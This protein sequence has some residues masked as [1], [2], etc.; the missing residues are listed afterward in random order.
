[1]S[2]PTPT[3]GFS[4]FLHKFLCLRSAPRELWII[5]IAYVLENIAYKLSSG[6][7]LPLWLAHELGMSDTT[8]GLTIG[9]WS[10]LLT[11]FTVLVGS[12]TDAVGIRRTFLLGFAICA[13]A[14]IAMLFSSPQIIPLGL[15]LLPLA[16]G[17]ALMTPV[18]T[19]AMKRYS[20]AAQRSVAFSLYY[21]LM[22][23]G[24]AIG[25][26]MFDYFRKQ[27][28]E[29]GVWVAPYFGA[30]FST[31]EVMILWSVIITI[32]GL[33]LTWL[34]LREGVEMTEEGVKITP[35]EK[36][37]HAGQNS[38]VAAARIFG[39]LWGQKTFHRFLLFMALIVGVR[40]IFYHLNYTLPDYAIRELGKGAPFAQICNMLNSLMILALVPVCGVL[41]QNISAYRMVSVGSLV[42]ALSVFVLAVPPELFKPM[43]DGWL[44]HLIVHQWLEVAGPVNPLYLS[45]FWF[46]VILSLGEALWSP[47]L[48]EYAAAIAPKGQEASY[49]ALSMLPYFFA[50][51]GAGSLSGWLLTKYCPAE[52][53]RNPAGMW[54]LIGVMALITPIGTFLFRKHIQLKEDGREL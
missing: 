45:I 34:F 48:Y 52:G 4:G 29:Y 42:S 53:A 6:S 23:L 30:N 25:D 54:I 1:M 40:M 51:F 46:T 33:L 28:G 18:M 14:R 49:M 15:G 36:R 39:G 2:Q 20:N 12:F 35:H 37:E 44:G 50:K 24:F 31:Y 26:R 5:F 32:P 16:L 27:M 21:A 10:A 43:A 9:I 17:L 38:L 8:K 19:A 13:V 41:T 11:L 22:N 7:V 47:R 3:K